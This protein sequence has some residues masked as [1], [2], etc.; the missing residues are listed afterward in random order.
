MIS[1]DDHRATP[2]WTSP[3]SNTVTFHVITCDEGMYAG[4]GDGGDGVVAQPGASLNLQA[5]AEA[6]EGAVVPRTGESSVLDGLAGGESRTERIS[7]ST[8]PVS[9]GD[10]LRVHVRRGK[11]GSS[12]LTG[13]RLI[14]VDS[15]EGAES[16]SLA[17]RAFAGQELAAIAV[18]HQDRSNHVSELGDDDNPY[19]G[20]TGDTLLISLPQAPGLAPSTPLPLAIRASGPPPPSAGVGGGF[21]VQASDG[22]GGWTTLG[23]HVP[24]DQFATFATDSVGGLFARIV[25]LTSLDISSIGRLA[26]AAQAAA[27]QAKLASALHHSRLGALEHTALADSAGVTLAARDTLLLDFPATFSE[28]ANGM[29]RSWVLELSGRDPNRP[30]AFSARSELAE[31]LPTRFALEQNRPN[32]FS[33][34]TTFRFALPVASAVKLELYDMQGRR[35]HTLASGRYAAG[36]HTLNWDRGLPHG[37]RAQAGVY[38]CRMTA[39][40]FLEVRKLIVY[41]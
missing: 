6:H 11:S 27:S 23:R 32:P 7:L 36:W 15:P 19:H 13:A 18:L 4:G 37:G 28:P 41:P 5:V 12:T 35:I 1:I 9:V 33:S 17:T 39:G 38:M 29:T 26:P 16:V 20:F 14:A 40:S 24:H 3:L 2:P 10:A 21:L 25:L 31:P 34:L 8:P 30:G 22:Q